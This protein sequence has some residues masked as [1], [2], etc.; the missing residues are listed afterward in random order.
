MTCRRGRSAAYSL[1]L[2]PAEIVAF[3]KLKAHLR[4]S[5]ARNCD[6]LAKILGNICGIFDPGGRWN[7]SKA[8]GYAS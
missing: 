5:G 7:F 4:R 1:S 3:S 8:A 6:Q 2:N